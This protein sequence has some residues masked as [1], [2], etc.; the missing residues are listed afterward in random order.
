M[1]ANAALLPHACD[2]PVDRRLTQRHAEK[3]AND[4]EKQFY[5]VAAMHRHKPAY[6]IPGLA[7]IT[8]L[9]ERIPVVPEIARVAADHLVRP[10]SIQDDLDAPRC[11][12]LHQIE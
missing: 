12:Q 11:G 3:M 7:V 2:T 8:R 6:F 4:S 5:L 10:V 1:S 9:H